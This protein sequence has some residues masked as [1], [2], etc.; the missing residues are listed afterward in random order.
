MTLLHVNANGCLWSPNDRD[1]PEL[2]DLLAA[3]PEEMPVPVLVHGFRYAPELA[4]RDPHRLILSH[5]ES[6]ADGDLPWPRHLGISK[7]GPDLAIAFGWNA[8]GSF[9]RAR[10][11]AARAG[12]ALAAL[13]V[14]IR[15]RSPGRRVTVLAHSLGARVALSA[16]P[17]LSPGDIGRAILLFPAVLRAE[18]E[19]AMATGAGRTAEIVNVTSRENRLFD[20][21]ATFLASGGL[22]RPVGR[23]LAGQYPGWCDLRIDCPETL[24]HLRD[25]GFQIGGRDRHICHWSSYMR[26]GVFALYRALIA[27]AA[28]LPLDRLVP[29]APSLAPDLWPTPCDRVEI[30]LN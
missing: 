6:L 26:P 7:A 2:D 22:R 14:R 20:L 8:H 11:E 16:L 18:A 27:E 25:L 29:Q 24:D 28:A 15:A 13:I 5:A 23:G 10:S 21:C 30:A 12:L 9:W 1:G 3:L 4:H 19:M 17:A